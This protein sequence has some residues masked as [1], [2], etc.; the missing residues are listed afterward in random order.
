MNILFGLFRRIFHCKVSRDN[1]V[2]IQTS[3]E[4]EESEIDTRQI[5]ETF[6]FK[7]SI[8]VFGAT[9]P[10]DKWVG[11]GALQAGGGCRGVKLTFHLCPVPKLKLVEL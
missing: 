6:V 3:W 11:G 10:R 7:M 9:Q 5:K 8:S 4:T 1:S 2:G